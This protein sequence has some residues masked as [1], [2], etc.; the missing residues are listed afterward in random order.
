L[1]AEQRQLVQPLA[2]EAAVDLFCARAAAVEPVFALTPSNR[3]TLAAICERL[4][5]LPLAIELC[6]AQADFLIPEQLLTHLQE[7][8]L[9]ALVHGAQDLPA[10]Q[11]TLRGAIGYSYDLLEEDERRLL[12][13]I[14]VFA[15]GG[16]L[17]AITAVSNCA[18]WSSATQ[19]LVALQALVASNLVQAQTTGDGARRFVLLETIREF[20]VEQLKAQGEEETLRQCHYTVFL[21]FA[22]T[23]DLELRGPDAHTWFARFDA[24]MDNVR[25][26]LQW[27]FDSE[28]YADVAWLVLVASWYWLVCGLRSE[29]AGVVARLLPHRRD[30]ADD[31]RLAI[32]LWGCAFPVRDEPFAQEE[33]LAAEIM[34][35]LDRCPDPLLRAAAWNWLA[36]RTSDLAAAGEAYERAITLAHAAH[37]LR[38][39]GTAWGLLGDGDFL[40][41]ANIS[42]YA[43]RLLDE[44]VAD[45]AAPLAAESLA[46]FQRRGDR[47]GISDTLAITG[48]L[49]LMQGDLDAAYTL[50][51]QSRTMITAFEGLSWRLDWQYLLGL[52]TL[53]RGDASTAQALL[54]DTLRLT[55]DLK[56]NLGAAR[57]CVYLAD[58]ALLDGNLA[59]A[60]QWLRQS[61]AWYA[62]P[63]PIFIYAVER[64]FVAARLAAAR[65]RH[66]RSAELFGLAEQAH[67]CVH[68]AHL[69]PQ[70]VLAEKALASVRQALDAADFAAAYAAGK[71]Q[72]VDGL[73]GKITRPPNMAL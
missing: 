2:L 72:T 27:A 20:A 35:L 44:G 53:Y 16:D 65:G 11:R 47:S 61:V 31:L 49:A 48:Q 39:M 45:R 6:A 22:R 15:G 26:A 63:Q 33:Q 25:A 9:N 68:H 19:P 67:A 66:R 58:A 42:N 55:A 5:R 59:E 64:I 28:R 13:S 62:E 54:A 7:A 23:A 21:Q 17:A 60:E 4:D 29:G 10:R 50:L 30:L 46:L 40:L 69:G 37:E 3:P 1:R 8:R 51:C 32:L 12:R 56:P 34:A 57:T 24:E 73:F 18:Q 43:K 70:Q 71:Q 41:A 36:V 52:V 38:E 14:G